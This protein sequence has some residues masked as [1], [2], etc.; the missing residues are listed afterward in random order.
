[1]ALIV[2][3]ACACAGAFMYVRARP[4]VRAGEIGT[5]LAASAQ[6]F[7]HPRSRVRT[8]LIYGGSGNGTRVCKCVKVCAVAF[9]ISFC[10]AIG[11]MQCEVIVMFK[12]PRDQHDNGMQ[13]ATLRKVL[14]RAL[15]LLAASRRA[16]RPPP[17][18]GRRRTA[19]PRCGRQQR[20]A[21]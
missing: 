20:G 8:T 16:K 14:A 1:M 2:Q 6:M 18:R 15:Q 10:M 21:L 9:C 13:N 12:H 4:C 3:C 5:A 11:E 7:S 17:R 19:G